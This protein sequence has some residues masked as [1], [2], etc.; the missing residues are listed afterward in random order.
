M[1]GVDPAALI[2]LSNAIADDLFGD[3]V[4]LIGQALAEVLPAEAAAGPAGLRRR[5]VLKGRDYVLHTQPLGDRDG[6][7]GS[8]LCLVPGAE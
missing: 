5:L 1:L 8:L 3:G 2:V 4:P 6:A 7:A